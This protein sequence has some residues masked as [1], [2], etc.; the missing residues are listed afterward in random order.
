MESK[1]MQ[2]VEGLVQRRVQDLMPVCNHNELREERVRACR[3]MWCDELLR[4]CSVL[5]R[6]PH[7]KTAYAEALAT[8]TTT[9]KFKIDYKLFTYV[10]DDVKAKVLP[11]G[12]VVIDPSNDDIPGRAARLQTHII[13]KDA[14]SF[15]DWIGISKDMDRRAILIEVWYHLVSVMHV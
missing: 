9:H 10:L 6:P 3:S 12:S 1:I 15:F 11:Y 13:F 8:G 14:A 4:Q 7:Q 5:P 2:R